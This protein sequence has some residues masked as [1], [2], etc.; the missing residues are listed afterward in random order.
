MVATLEAT[1]AN[2][3]LHVVYPEFEHQIQEAHCIMTQYSPL[4]WRRFDG[5]LRVY[6]AIVYLYSASRCIRRQAC[7]KHNLA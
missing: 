1:R 7:P 6:L 2:S 3:T 4:I 5:S